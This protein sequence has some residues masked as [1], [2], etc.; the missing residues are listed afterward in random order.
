MAAPYVDSIKWD[1]FEYRSVY[2]A[3]KLHRG[4]FEWGFLYKESDVPRKERDKHYYSS[5]PNW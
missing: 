3:G 2:G 5:E 1:T 4:I